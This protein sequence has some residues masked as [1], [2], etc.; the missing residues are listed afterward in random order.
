MLPLVRPFRL[1]EWVAARDGVG[2][3]IGCKRTDEGVF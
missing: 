1:G 3:F 2:V